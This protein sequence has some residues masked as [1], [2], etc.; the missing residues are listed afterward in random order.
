MDTEIIQRHIQMV[1]PKDVV[2][3]AGDFTLSKKSFAENYIRQLAGTHIF[4]KGSH[5]YWLKKS[6]AVIR[7]REIM[8]NRPDNSN[9][10]G[11]KA[12]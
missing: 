1:G 10:V 9:F 3:H 5:D 8:Q 7:E 2:I 4:L 6:A 11:N 12:A